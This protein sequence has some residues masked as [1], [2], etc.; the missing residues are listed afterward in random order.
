MRKETKR[1]L[2]RAYKVATKNEKGHLNPWFF[3]G[4]LESSG[5]KKLPGDEVFRIM[6]WLWNWDKKRKFFA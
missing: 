4:Y 1:L 3:L 2:K 5:L 6:F